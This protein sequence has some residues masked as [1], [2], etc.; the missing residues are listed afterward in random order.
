MLWIDNEN[1]SILFSQKSDGDMYFQ[2]LTNADDKRIDTDSRNSKVKLNRAKFFGENNIDPARLANIEAVHGNLIYKVEEKDLGSGALEPGTRIKGADGLITNIKNS[3]LM[4]TGADCFPVFFYDSK[5]Q[6]AGIAHCGWRGIIKK[7]IKETILKLRNSFGSDPA[8]VNVWV[9]P[10]IK[11]C[12]YSVDKERAELFSKNY[13]KHII[14]RDNRIFLDLAGIIAL[15]LTVAG[16][17]PEK[18][19]T[20]PDC[21]F[22]EKEKWSSY[23]RD[24]DNYQGAAAFI[25]H[26][27]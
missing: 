1:I 4:V 3:Y 23:R 10:G 17:R 5:K 14:E 8:D 18:I 15:Q 9:G 22:C 13:K 26:L 25:I 12:H 11:S 16:V 20:H 24:K 21:T 7:I 27:K 6:V 2:T 19:I